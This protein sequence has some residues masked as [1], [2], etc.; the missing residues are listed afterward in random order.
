MLAGCAFTGKL[1]YAVSNDGYLAILDPKDGKI[2]EKKTYLNDQGKAG[3]GRCYCSPQVV[4]D[5]ANGR[6]IVGSE[7]GGLRCYVGL[8]SAE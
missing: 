5:G 8:R 3:G 2:V 7:T 4:N 1:V 6:V